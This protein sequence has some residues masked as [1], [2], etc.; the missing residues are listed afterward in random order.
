MTN[1]KNTI[2]LSILLTQACLLLYKRIM[3]DD[4]LIFPTFIEEYQ[5]FFT[6]TTIL[7]IDDNTVTANT[8]TE[9]RIKKR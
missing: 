6:Y 1:T 2:K 5:M 9:R 8:D 4:R 7:Q 3:D